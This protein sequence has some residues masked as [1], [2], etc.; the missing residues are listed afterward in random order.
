MDLQRLVVVRCLQRHGAT[1]AAAASAQ[2]CRLRCTDGYRYRE[3]AGFFRDPSH[4]RWA[5]PWADDAGRGWTRLE[6]L[7][8]S[9]ATTAATKQRR[10]QPDAETAAD[11]TDA[12]SGQ[13]GETIEAEE[14]GEADDSLKKRE[15]LD[16]DP[17]IPANLG[18]PEK[19]WG[20]A[21]AI[22][23]VQNS[24]FISASVPLALKRAVW[25]NDVPAVR[26]HIHAH[27]AISSPDSHTTNTLSLQQARLLVQLNRR[28]SLT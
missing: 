2:Q 23:T 3:G 21:E 5:E 17:K 13:G 10:L 11:A 26:E 9:A 1:A 16:I 28:K 22:R 12:D 18:Q 6:G 19:P 15:G 25:Y 7:R 24:P 8:L 20:P 27:G 4:P 14:A